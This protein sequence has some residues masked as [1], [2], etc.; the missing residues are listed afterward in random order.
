M[1]YLRPGSPSMALATNVC[2]SSGVRAAGLNAVLEAWATAGS[3]V[4]SRGV[5]AVLTGGEMKTGRLERGAESPPSGMLT[6]M[7]TGVVGGESSICAGLL[8][9]SAPA[10]VL[11]SMSPS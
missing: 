4:T 9:V 1:V 2:M 11:D 8:G 7:R 10:V 6:L 3:S 5:A